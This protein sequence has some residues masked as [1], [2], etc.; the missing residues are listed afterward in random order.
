MCISQQE[1][2]K[3]REKCEKDRLDI[4]SELAKYFGIKREVAEILFMGF[5]YGR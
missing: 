4:Y 2:N 3:L 5:N 1:F